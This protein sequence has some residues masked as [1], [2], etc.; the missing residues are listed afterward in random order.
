[1]RIIAGL[2]LCL[3]LLL[4]AASNAAEQDAAELVKQAISTAGGETKLLKLFRMKEQLNVSSD[5]TKKG[6]VR[7]SVLEPPKYWWLGKN[8]RV[9][10]EKEPAT[11][12]VWAWTLGALTDP[13]SKIELLP[14]ATEDGVTTLPLRISQSITPPMDLH[15]DKTE[16]RLVR[17]EWRSDIHRFSDWREHD[18]V[19]YPAK[20]VGYKKATGKPWYFSEI[21]EL[22]RLSELPEGLQ[23]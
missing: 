11:F 19:K 9:K 12:L 10:D 15:F 8:E 22:E 2:S 6:S 3:V 21:V 1:M 20:C 18:G 5:A 14:E 7:L 16:K 13:Q 23:R 4:A 17:I